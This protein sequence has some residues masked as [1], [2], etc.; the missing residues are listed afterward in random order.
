MSEN[1]AIHP[2]QLDGP[3]DA[4]SLHS[5]RSEAV[6]FGSGQG[7]WLPAT[8]LSEF[9]TAGVVSYVEDFKRAKTPLFIHRSWMDQKMP[10]LNGH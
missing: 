10:L 8:S 4:A 3:K 6:A 9:E 2:P 5:V 7:R 1:A